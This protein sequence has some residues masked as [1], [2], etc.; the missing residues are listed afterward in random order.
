MKIGE[1]KAQALMLMGVN[2]SLNITWAEI[3]SYKEDPTYATYIYAM[4]GAI[5]RC[6]KRLY[7]AGALNEQPTSILS[8]EDETQEITAFAPDITDTLADMIPLYVVGDV[9]AVEEPSVAQNKRNEFE[10]LLE[11]YL[12]RRAFPAQDKVDIVY[13]V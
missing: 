2:N 13:G 7:T 11:E 3:D 12:N 1:I 9:Y 6:L 4:G 8:S 5:S 10:A